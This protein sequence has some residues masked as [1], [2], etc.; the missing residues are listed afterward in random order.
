MRVL[1]D[2]VLTELAKEVMVICHL[3]KLEATATYQWTDYDQSVHFASN[4]WL[5]KGIV[6][7]D[8]EYNLS[9]EVPSLTFTYPN[10]DKAF[11]D[12]ALAQDLRNKPFSIYRVML[13][14][15]L[16]VIGYTTEA[17]L[18]DD[19]VFKGFIDQIPQMDRLNARVSVV[20]HRIT[21]GGLGPG[22]THSGMCWKKF[23][24]TECTYVDGTIHPADDSWCDQS[25]SRCKTLL[26]AVNFG[27]WEYISELVDKELMW[28]SRVKNWSKR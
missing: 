2:S 6:F 27:G 14:S 28:G 4:Y 22:R 10:A 20:G 19:A 17:E 24:S 16:G 1:P 9:A 3:F 25:K 13:N 12:I 11:S 7:D 8:F 26:N 18:D 21:E 5:N 23:K 15:S